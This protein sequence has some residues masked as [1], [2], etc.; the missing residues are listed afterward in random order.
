MVDK[1]GIEWRDIPGWDNYQASEDG[2]VRNKT[3]GQIMKQHASGS[4]GYPAIRLSYG[5]SRNKIQRVHRLV[6]SAFNG[7]I[8]EGMEIDHLDSVVDNNH[9]DNLECVTPKENRLR[10]YHPSG[11]EHPQRRGKFARQRS[12]RVAKVKE[13]LGIIS[14]RAIARAL[15]VSHNLV[16]RIQRGELDEWD[17]EDR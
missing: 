12:N 15:R 14:N 7:E 17:Q 11:D 3:T 1:N 2:R 8:P 5:G 13:L 9:K 6:W 4:M 16:G 10:Q